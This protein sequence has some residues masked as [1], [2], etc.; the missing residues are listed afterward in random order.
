MYTTL[1]KRYAPYGMKQGLDDDQEIM[2]V[3]AI[4]IHLT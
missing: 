4:Y 1:A 3:V 2:Y